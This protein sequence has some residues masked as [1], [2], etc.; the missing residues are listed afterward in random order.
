MFSN[1]AMVIRHLDFSLS[2]L[3][4]VWLDVVSLFL[5]TASVVRMLQRTETVSAV[6]IFSL[7]ASTHLLKS[8]AQTTH[9]FAAVV[10]II[11]T[12]LFLPLIIFACLLRRPMS[13]AALL[14]LFSAI[15]A[16]FSN[17]GQIDVLKL[18]QQM[19][20]DRE[21]FIWCTK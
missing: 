3:N 8:S 20:G 11:L 15:T 10:I 21:S 4:S 1:V 5:L 2:R 17:N 7:S 9:L 14:L 16:I 13:P 6:N 18:L 12:F 19:Q